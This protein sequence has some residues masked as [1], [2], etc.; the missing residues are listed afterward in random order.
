L[1]SKTLKI[2]Q[3]Q[4]RFEAPNF[5]QASPNFVEDS[6]SP[7]FQRI[8]PNRNAIARQKKRSKQGTLP[9]LF[10]CDSVT[11]RERYSSWRPHGGFFKDHKNRLSVPKT[12]GAL[13]VVP[14]DVQGGTPHSGKILQ[15]RLSATRVSKAE[16]VQMTCPP[17]GRVQALAQGAV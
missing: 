8:V 17:S 2:S 7:A 5:E 10:P 15:Q 3:R 13:S 1:K 16:S 4:A 9:D 14:Q 11:R 12:I 6:S